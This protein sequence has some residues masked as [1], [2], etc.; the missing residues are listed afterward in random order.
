MDKDRNN[1][2]KVPQSSRDTPWFIMGTYQSHSNQST[3]KCRIG[4]AA[5]KAKKNKS[6]TSQHCQQRK[7]TL[8][9]AIQHQRGRVF[10]TNDMF[11][12]IKGLQVGA[13]LLQ[14]QTLATE[15]SICPRY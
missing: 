15:P 6:R 3:R 13:C 2:G 9:M 1:N 10:T 4:K 11:H 14:L 12:I 7:T 5:I 8:S